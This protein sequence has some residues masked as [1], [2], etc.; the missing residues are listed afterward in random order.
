MGRISEGEADPL[1][2]LAMQYADYAVWQRQWM[3]GEVCSEQGEY[4]KTDVGGS[5]G[6]AGVAGG[7]SAAGAAGL[8][9]G[10]VQGWCWMRS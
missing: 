10:V 4:W 3:E 8:C 6:V 5:A 2:E 1:P 9:G 7:P